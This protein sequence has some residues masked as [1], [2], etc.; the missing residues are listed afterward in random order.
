M[1][2][3]LLCKLGIHKRVV[4]ELLLPNKKETMYYAICKYCG[5]GDPRKDGKYL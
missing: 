4:V 3:K 1:I 2:Q 5:D